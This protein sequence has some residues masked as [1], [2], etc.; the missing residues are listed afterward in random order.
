MRFTTFAGAAGRLAMLR[1]GLGLDEHRQT[2][3]VFSRPSVPC[4]R[5]PTR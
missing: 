4:P 1:S 3:V 2:L 5:L